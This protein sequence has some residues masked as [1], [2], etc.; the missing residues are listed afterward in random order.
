MFRRLLRSKRRTDVEDAP[1][2]SPSWLWNTS[3]SSVT[4]AP[5]EDC[6]EDNATFSDDRDDVF[7]LPG[8][9][10]WPSP[11]TNFKNRDEDLSVAS[12]VQS[13]WST[14]TARAVTRSKGAGNVQSREAVM[15][16]LGLQ[17]GVF[18]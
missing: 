9:Q 13:L 2:G 3:S 12:C 14:R 5:P 1:S 11:G 8:L 10:D 4:A 15:G 17:V 7:S 16:K 18:P 6:P